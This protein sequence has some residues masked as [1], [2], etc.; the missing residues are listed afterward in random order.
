[1]LR[2][3]ITLLPLVLMAFGL[4]PILFASGSEHDPWSTDGKQFCGHDD[5]MDRFLRGESRARPNLSGTETYISTTHF[6]VW[7][8]TTGYDSSTYAYADSVSHY[9]EFCWTRDSTL[10][11]ALPPPDG[12]QGGDSK[13]DIYIRNTDTLDYS[14]VCY[15]ESPYTTPYP[16]GYSSWVEVERNSA[17]YQRLTALVAHEFSH[18]CQK[19]FSQIEDDPERFIY[20][21]TSVYM[22]DMCYDNVN[23]L[24]DRLAENPGHIT[25]PHWAIT[26]RQ[27]H[28]HYTGGLFATFLDEYYNPTVCQPILQIWTLFGNHSGTHT[29]VDIDSVLRINYNSSFQ[30]A[31]GHY[32]IWRYFCD[33]LDDGMHFIEGADYYTT[34]PRRRWTTYPVSSNEGIWAPDGPGGCNYNTLL[35]YGSTNNLTIYFNGQNGYEWAVYLLAYNGTT[36]Y[37]YKMVLDATQDTGTI[38]LSGSVFPTKIVMIPVIV[39]WTSLSYDLTYDFTASI[40]PSVIGVSEARSGAP[41][42][43]KFDISPNPISDNAIITYAIKADGAPTISVFDAAGRLVDDIRNSSSPF[44]WDRTDAFGNWLPAGAYFIRLEGRDVAVTKKIVL[45]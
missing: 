23:T 25:T 20:E 33:S 42:V 39:Q 7:Y 8:T 12:T 41:E 11:W 10:G 16:D 21:N 38:V 9:A 13:Y 22:E 44:R 1:M 24:Y 14:G 2:T 29:R 4:T 31:L 30:K 32:A 35:N 43:P 45:R 3:R 40:S 17:T 27:D 26:V 37:E 5:A 34:V 15:E 6:R 18:G 28:F 36:S 19:R